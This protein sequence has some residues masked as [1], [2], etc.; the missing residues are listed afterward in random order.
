MWRR[1]A[2]TPSRLLV[3]EWWPS[4]GHLYAHVVPRSEDG[5]LDEAGVREQWWRTRA[6]DEDVQRQ[7]G[8]LSQC[9]LWPAV[10]RNRDISYSVWRNVF[11]R[12]DSSTRREC[13]TWLARNVD[14]KRELEAFVDTFLADFDAERSWA[15]LASTASSAF[16]EKHAPRFRSYG[17]VW[18]QIARRHARQNPCWFVAFVDQHAEWVATNETVLDMLMD[19]HELMR[20]VLALHVANKYDRALQVHLPRVIVDM[21]GDY[22]LQE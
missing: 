6:R 7:E 14:G 13:A 10:A 5:Q 18:E 20:E 8:F 22:C 15:A 9:K 16:L 4:H 21:V 3:A 17:W 11:P 2:A 12:L 19:N 1:L